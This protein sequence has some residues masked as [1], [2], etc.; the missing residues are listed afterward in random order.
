[1]SVF[2]MSS[3]SFFVYVLCLVIVLEPLMQFPAQLDL[4]KIECR[5][6]HPLLL[7]DVAVVAPAITAVKVFASCT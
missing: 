7:H 5:L 1:M 2:I 4:D 6:T 3:S